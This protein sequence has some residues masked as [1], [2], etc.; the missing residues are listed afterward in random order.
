[1]ELFLYQKRRCYICKAIS[2]DL[3]MYKLL[4]FRKTALSIALLFMLSLGVQA[5]EVFVKVTDVSQFVAD[6]EYI[7]AYDAGSTAYVATTEKGIPSNKPKVEGRASQTATM[8]EGKLLLEDKGYV[9]RFHLKGVVHEGTLVYQ[10]WTDN[11][12]LLRDKNNNLVLDADAT[13][14]TTYFAYGS[15]DGVPYLYRPSAKNRY[16]VFNWTKKVFW[17]NRV[18][19]LNPKDQTNRVPCLYIKEGSPFAYT[20]EGVGERIVLYASEAGIALGRVASG[21]NAVADLPFAKGTLFTN[22]NR[23]VASLKKVQSGE[24]LLLL[25]E[26]KEYLSIVNGELTFVKDASQGASSWFLCEKGEEVRL[27]NTTTQQAVSYIANEGFVLT[28]DVAQATV[29]VL[30]QSA[31]QHLTVQNVGYAT[32]FTDATYIMPE[33]LKGSSVIAKNEIAPIALE[34]PYEYPAGSVVPARTPLLIQSVSET[35]AGLFSLLP[36]TEEG[37]VA[38]EDNLL[39]GQLLDGTIVKKAGDNLYYKLTYSNDDTRFGFFWGADEGDVFE[40][41]KNRA[42]LVLPKSVELPS[43]GFYLEDENITGIDPIL[44]KE[45]NKN[46]PACYDLLGRRVKTNLR[47]IYI[48]NSN[49]WLQR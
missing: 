43:P 22:R 23:E 11:N 13:V 27:V 20:K 21:L 44:I 34:T 35:K 41:P 2:C 39:H 45:K 8:E 17:P 48:T 15:K 16:L 30:G 29:E 46:R 1:M 25:N 9:L 28:D 6:A 32:Y 33:G 5:Q 26:Q 3:I 4:S 12:L 19:N 24:N 37:L 7:L 14:Q 10:L 42:Y 40:M 49:K 31:V 47:G 36:T 18:A 38:R